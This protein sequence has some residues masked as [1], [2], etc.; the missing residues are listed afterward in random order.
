MKKIAV[1]GAGSWGATIAILLAAKNYQIILWDK[2]EN[3]LKEIAQY[4]ENKRYLPNIKL[5]DNIEIEFN[6]ISAIKQAEYLVI[7]IPT[8]FI[9]SVF[10][11]ISKELIK[12]K[13]IINLSKGIELQKLKRISEIFTELF[14]CEILNQYCVLTGPSHSEEVSQKLP[15]SVIVASLNKQQALICQEIFNTD[16]FRVYTSDDLIGAEIGGAVKNVIAIA[17]GICD[18]LKLGD[19]ARAALITRGL[20]EI[21]RFGAAFG[22]KPQTFAGLSGLGDLIVTCGSIH[23]RNYRCGK[24]LG[25][26]EQIQ[27]IKLKIGQIIEGLSTVESVC[28]LAKTK[29]IEM[30]ICEQVLKVIKNEMTPK[31]SVSALMTRLTKQEFHL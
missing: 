14:S 19:N 7:A 6:L 18:G 9:R 23:S 12:N 17:A 16:Y 2:I 20:A 1:L 30:P 27:N 5:P 29:N 24:Y 26:G 28:S 11:N 3:H 21:T 4:R 8:Q 25:E 15:T 13:V 31:Q 10:E 22:A